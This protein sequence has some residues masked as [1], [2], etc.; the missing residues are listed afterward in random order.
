MAA[1]VLDSI[2]SSDGVHADPV[3]L[4]AP[5]ADAVRAAG[6]LYVADEVQPGF[7]RTG[8]W[9]GF[10]RH[11]VVP[12]LMVLGKPMGNGLPISAVVGTVDAQASFGR[13][14]RYFNTFGGNPVSIAA[15]AAVLDVIEGDGLVSHAAETGERLR[16]GIE[17]IAAVSP[18]V[19]A[20]RGTG[21]FVG[22]DLV[23]D[24]GE[25]SSAVASRVVNAMRR[26]RVLIS[27][28]G[29]RAAT[30]KI[31]PPLPFRSEHVDRLLE[32][33]ERAIGGAA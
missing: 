14:V 18:R 29:P 23:G 9:W 12:D 33:L 1:L 17:A 16:W 6:G 20:V 15:A 31:R 24:D 5:A 10:E 7:G 13:D 2:F 8:A 21:L 19:S 28:S 32:S 25:P 27:A 11:G 26:D 4:L 22:V 3:G 30:L